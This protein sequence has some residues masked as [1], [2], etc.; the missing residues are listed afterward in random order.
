MVPVPRWETQSSHLLSSLADTNPLLH[1]SPWSIK[2]LCISVF[3]H[4]RD[5]SSTNILPT[6]TIN[7]TS[8]ALPTPASSHIYH[9]QHYH[10][11]IEQH[12]LHGVEIS[13]L[14][15]YSFLRSLLGYVDGTFT[16][17]LTTDPAYENWHRTAENIRLWLSSYPTNNC[18]INL[19]YNKLYV[20]KL[21]IEN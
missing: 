21:N 18:D 12:K 14:Y 11:P 7:P 2:F 20:I 17:P 10:R 19:N 1:Q 8:A 4:P 13:L 15:S 6:V 9:H 5:S 16:P 3:L